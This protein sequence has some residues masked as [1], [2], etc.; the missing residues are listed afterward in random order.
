MNAY[1]VIEENKMR[2]YGGSTTGMQI[3]TEVNKFM[4]KTVQTS[5]KEY[6]QFKCIQ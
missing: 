4:L 2:V 1:W 3:V 5:D 6:T